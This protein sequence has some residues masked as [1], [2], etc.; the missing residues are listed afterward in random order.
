MKEMFNLRMRSK[1]IPVFLAADNKYVK[2]MMVT[3]RSIIANATHNHQYRLYVLHT[4]I[5]VENQAMVKRMEV[6]NFQ[7]SFVDVTGELRK[8]EKKMSL[9]DYYTATT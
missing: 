7:I 6:S 3:I 4:D 2:F 9:R 8:I 1:V 5:S